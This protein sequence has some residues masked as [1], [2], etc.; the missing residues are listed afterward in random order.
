MNG[1]VRLFAAVCRVL[2][3]RAFTARYGVELTATFAQGYRIARRG[4]RWAALSFTM[5]ELC[6][7][8]ATAVQQRRAISAPAVWP[9][10]RRRGD[11]WNVLFDVAYALR[12]MRRS[13]LYAATVA[14]TL[15]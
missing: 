13:P 10:A 7:V 15:A 2:L 3:P 4:S 9:P 12:I 1:A 11:M 14:V 5:R 6:A 8:V